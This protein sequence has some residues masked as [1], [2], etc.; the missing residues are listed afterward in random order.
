MGINL[1]GWPAPEKE[2][3][4]VRPV[5]K[6]DASMKMVYLDSLINYMGNDSYNNSSRRSW[7]WAA[8]VDPTEITNAKWNEVV[9][10]ASANDYTG[11]PM[12]PNL[13]PD[14]PRTGIT[15]GRQSS[16][17]MPGPRWMV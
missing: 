5:G 17:A 15:F 1:P 7:C 10:W 13:N 12:G 9:E 11:L 3:I 8:R 4:P 14:H 6:R 2:E 16:G